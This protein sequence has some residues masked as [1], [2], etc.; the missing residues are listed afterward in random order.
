MTYD[1]TAKWSVSPVISNNRRAQTGRIEEPRCGEIE[2]ELRN[3]VGEQ[4]GRL[5]IE[6]GC[7]IGVELALYRYDGSGSGA[8]RRQ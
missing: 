4:A 8:I 1:S 3:V 5:L 2:D 6:A 7:G